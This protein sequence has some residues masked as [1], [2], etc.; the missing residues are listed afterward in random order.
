MSRVKGGLQHN[1]RRKSIL[2]HT[3]GFKWGRKSKIKLARTAKMKAGQH[4]FDSRKVKKRINRGLW[5]IRINAAV[6]KV[7]LNY[8][9]FISTL[10][11]SGSVLDRKVLSVI[12]MQFP[13]VFDQIVTHVKK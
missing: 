8:S 3:K 1:K 6:R 12:A 11:K 7:G 2:K 9:G 5:Q 10:K 13:T 4:A